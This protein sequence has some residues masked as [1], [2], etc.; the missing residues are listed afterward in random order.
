[1]WRSVLRACLAHRPAVMA[2]TPRRPGFYLALD[3]QNTASLGEVSATYLRKSASICGSTVFPLRVHS[4]PFAVK[5]CKPAH[6][7]SAVSSPAV[8]FADRDTKRSFVGVRIRRLRRSG[9]PWCEPATKCHLTWLQV[10]PEWLPRQA[11]RREAWG[12]QLIAE[13]I[14]PE[15]QNTA[16]RPVR[17]CAHTHRAQYKQRRSAPIQ[18]GC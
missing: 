1:L 2:K 14:V 18:A 6:T 15:S 9:P 3:L 8:L 4:R 16:A 7:R 13:R 11:K 5:E 10:D 12:R 17:F